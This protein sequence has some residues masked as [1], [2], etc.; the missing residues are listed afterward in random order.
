MNIQDA[1]N[2]LKG[3]IS[4]LRD[5]EKGFQE[6]SKA[7][8]IMP[9]KNMCNLYANERSNM[10]DVL[11]AHLTDLGGEPPSTSTSFVSSLHRA[12]IDIKVGGWGDDFSSIVD[13]IERGSSVL[14]DEYQY[15]LNKVNLHSNLYMVLTKQQEQIN[16]ELNELVKFRR[17]VDAVNA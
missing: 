1:K 6:I 2:A 4:R 9:I 14:I 8:S 7:T 3:L 11:E 12:W 13:E 16:L 17:E 10:I 15:A 5:S